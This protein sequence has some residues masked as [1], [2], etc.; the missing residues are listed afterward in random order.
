MSIANVTLNNTF[1]EWRTVTNQLIHFVNDVDSGNL[2]KFYSNS[3]V[4]TVTENVARNGKNFITLNVSSNVLDTSTLNLATA[5][6]VNVVFAALANTDATIVLLSDAANVINDKTNSAFIVSNIAFVQANTGRDHAN[7]SFEQANTGRIHANSSFEQANTARVHANLGF[8]QANTGRIHANNAFEK[9]NAAFTLA[10]V[11]SGNSSNTIISNKAAFDTANLGFHQA[12]TARVHANASFEQAN[13]ARV[14]AN[15][16]FAAANNVAPQIT[17]TFIQANTARDHANAAFAAANTVA[18]Q[19]APVFS[20]A[21]TA[22]IHANNA[23][24]RANA[25]LP[26]TSG[27]SFA[28]NLQIPTGNLTLGAGTNQGIRLHVNHLN[29]VANVD[30]QIRILNGSQFVNFNANTSAGAWNDL[31]LN[32]DASIIYSRGTSDDDANLVI[33]PW[34]DS[35]FGYKQDGEGRHGFNT[36]NP[37]FTIDANGSAN[38][39]GSLLVG[40]QNVIPTLTASFIHAN[41]AH[42]SANAGLTQA[43]TARDHANAAFNKANSTT[44]TSNVVISVSDNAN[45]ALRITQLGTGEVLR[46][47]DDS[48][49]DATPFVIDATGNV[50]I[51][52]STSTVGND[53]KLDVAGGINV[54]AILINGSYSQS[55]ITLNGGGSAG[56]TIDCSIG[57]YFRKNVANAN[58]FFFSNVVSSRAYAFTFEL[59]LSGSAVI[60]WPASVRWP[61]DVAPTLSI[62]K[63]H[64]L[65]FLTDDSGSTW[66]GSSILNYTT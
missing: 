62:D 13:T 39:A 32:R 9:A 65:T 28:G 21:N 57:N 43:N 19:I 15:A 44:F 35:S 24:E 4:L 5:N 49:P 36:L 42:V 7:A 33:G 23:F 64:I 30:P 18:P 51:G 8:A 59:N 6:A 31:M 41:T 16:A 27:V 26:N 61:G 56:N 14:H 47:E 48:N 58:T 37:R 20:Q 50:L 46:V 17:P 11:A 25:A 53:V 40:N 2:T 45:A 52:R 38:I 12:N 3:A 54:A 1:D 34:T 66:R 29:T 63:T 55:I 10:E 22:R 60:T